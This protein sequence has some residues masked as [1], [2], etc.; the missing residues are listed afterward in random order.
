MR[1]STTQLYT[2]A[3][4]NMMEGQSKLAEI[5][6]KIASGKNFTSLADD[7]VGAN[8]VV[9][10]KRELAQ[11]EVYQSNID[12]TRRRLDLEEATLDQL[13]NAVT[14]AQELII[15][16][17]NGGLTDF[18]RAAISYELEE[19]VEYSTSLMNTRDAKGEYIFSGSKGSTQTYVQNIDGSYTYQGDNT[20]RQIQVGSSQF[21][22]STD[23]G[24]YL[25]EAVPGELG[26]ETLG[27]DVNPALS[28]A[29]TNFEVTDEAAFEKYMRST[30]DLRISLNQGAT[31]PISGDTTMYYSLTDSLGNPIPNLI[32]NSAT[33]WTSY[34]GVQSVDFEIPGA[35]FR[36]SLPATA[37][38]SEPDILA[39]GDG[40]DYFVT[41][42]ASAPNPSTT[43][44]AAFTDLFANYGPLRI[45]ASISDSAT[46][47]AATVTVFAYDEAQDEWVDITTDLT[48]V[49]SLAV[50]GPSFTGNPFSG[51]GTL[52]AGLFTT[53][54]SQP[55][56]AVSFD[57]FYGSN[58]PVPVTLS[59][60][61]LDGTYLNADDLATD[62]TNQL[63][64]AG[65]GV[66]VT[67]VNDRLVF[68]E[69]V[70]SAGTISLSNFNLGTSGVTLADF[71][72]VNSFVNLS[73]GGW[74]VNIDSS[75]D[76]ATSSFSLDFEPAEEVTLRFTKPN[77]NIL[78]ALADATDVLRNNS[79]NDEEEKTELFATLN[80][81]LTNL[82]VVQERFSQSVAGIGAR[83]NAM[84]SAEFSNLDFKLL[85]QS[86]LSAVEDV[87][88]AS[89]ST[90]LAK[91]QLALEAAYASFAK[92]QGL[93]LFDY[94]R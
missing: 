9:N 71:G 58:A 50:S 60:T 44:S 47:P 69:D 73:V 91:R 19:L 28:G 20:Q 38:G 27:I 62:I 12:S 53:D 57:V 59:G 33:E 67:A 90:E 15:Q 83:L 43:D 54:F 82:S 7:P 48:N 40:I 86:T 88:Y 49:A 75:A 13:N 46:T 6:N 3:N 94:L 32:D 14:R 63:Q 74:E 10:L 36:L 64:L 55:G 52:A 93:S 17:S 25:F 78:T 1:I 5:Q 39:T 2:E 18:D 61:Q 4:R 51:S 68:E 24:Q 23:T 92:I 29:L 85:T 34:V 70:S 30:G 21:L 45:D 87:D 66:T 16:A 89:A 22:A 26:I 77:T 42:S 35:T 41:S 56:D 79:I 72:L 80:A 37:G 8:Q 65:V 84:D 81:T 31:D 76:F 11:F